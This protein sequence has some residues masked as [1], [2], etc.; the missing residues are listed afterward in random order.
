MRGYTIICFWCYNVLQPI[1]IILCFK[2]MLLFMRICF[3][4][5]R[6]VLLINFLT[7]ASRYDLMIMIIRQNDI[8][9]TLFSLFS[10]TNITTLCALEKRSTSNDGIK[11]TVFVLILLRNEKYAHFTK[12]V[13]L[14]FLNYICKN[15]HL[16]KL[17]K[18]NIFLQCKFI[19]KFLYWFIMLIVYIFQFLLICHLILYSS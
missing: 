6:K 14:L 12:N 8:K 2:G 13:W 11:A 19:V 7:W 9:Q 1:H 10:H 16:L 17:L 15:C 3:F 18:F 5:W 4:Y